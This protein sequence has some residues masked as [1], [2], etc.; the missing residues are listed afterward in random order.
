[1]AHASARSL[2]SV[3]GIG[4]LYR[5]K[6]AYVDISHLLESVNKGYITVTR[7]GEVIPFNAFGNIRAARKKNFSE[8][9]CILLF[10]FGESQQ[11]LLNFRIHGV[12]LI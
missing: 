4:K 1:M 5:F 12:N 9:Q 11:E 2:K 3:F 8:Q 7:K 6:K 10:R